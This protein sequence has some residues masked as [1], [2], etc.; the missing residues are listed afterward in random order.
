MV[1]LKVTKAAGAGEA[2][3]HPL[4]AEKQDMGLQKQMCHPLPHFN[5]KEQ[6]LASEDSCMEMEPENLT[7]TS[8]GNSSLPGSYWPSHHLPC[9]QIHQSCLSSLHL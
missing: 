1:E 3:F 7:R 5:Q 2:L 9:L 4:P 6:R 8:F